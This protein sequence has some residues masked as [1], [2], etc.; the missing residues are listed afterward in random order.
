MLVLGLALVCAGIVILMIAV[1]GY[2]GVKERR[3]SQRCTPVDTDT[4][5]ET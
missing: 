4:K 3:N 1:L 2:L 5:D